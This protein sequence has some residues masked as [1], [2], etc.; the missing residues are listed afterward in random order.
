MSS[1]SRP[2]GS[3]TQPSMVE[4]ALYRIVQEAVTNIVKHARAMTV[5]I[6]VEQGPRRVRC[7]R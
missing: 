2:F 3:W 1:T 4:T 5:T 7:S 6:R